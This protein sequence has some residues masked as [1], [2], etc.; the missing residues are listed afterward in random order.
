MSEAADAGLDGKPVEVDT[1]DVEAA[2]KLSPKKSLKKKLTKSKSAVMWLATAEAGGEWPWPASSSDAKGETSPESG[3]G[4]TTETDGE[5]PKKQLS[6][7]LTKSKSAVMWLAMGEAGQDWPWPAGGESTE[8]DGDKSKK[9]GPTKK[10][11]SRA[12]KR[13]SGNAAGGDASAGSADGAASPGAAIRTA[14]K[15]K[16]KVSK[17]RSN[18]MMLKEDPDEGVDIPGESP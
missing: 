17:S 10:R 3:R 11:K 9:D 18:V 15:L 13:L 1:G 6:K 8:T 2:P 16:K 14:I 7:K 5:K 12:S 4:E